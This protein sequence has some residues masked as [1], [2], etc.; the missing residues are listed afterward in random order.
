MAYNRPYNPDE[1]PRFA[2]PEQKGG[3]APKP[4]QPPASQPRYESKPPPPVPRDDYHR[5]DPRNDHRRPSPNAMYGVSSPPPTGGPR[6]TAHHRPPPN[7]RPPPSPAPDASADGADPTLLPL[8]RAVDKDGTGQLSERELSTALVNG[9]WTAFDPQTVRMMIRMFDSDRSGT[10]GFAEFCGLWSFLASWRTLFDRFDA[11]RSGNI[12]LPE[13]S[14]ALV[15]FRY[16][17]SPGFVELLFRTYDKRGEGVMSFDLFVQACISLKRMTDVFKKYDD[18]RDG[19]ITLSFEDFLT[20][21]L[22]QLK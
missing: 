1:L 19:Y 4:S 7:S 8:F 17:L 3:A 11:D 20:E 14:N 22:K 6:P 15:A 12:S 18:D 13:F 16:R 2:E 5:P 9:D 21:I 10:I